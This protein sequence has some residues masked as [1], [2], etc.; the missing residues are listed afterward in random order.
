[1]SNSLF[2]EILLELK[3]KASVI[4]GKIANSLNNTSDFLKKFT[5]E[6]F[7]YVVLQSIIFITL[8]LIIIFRDPFELYAKYSLEVT[9]GMLFIFFIMF[10]TF[11]FIDH[12][13]QF[14]LSDEKGLWKNFIKKFSEWSHLPRLW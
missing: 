13:K 6:P 9:M 4:P 7:N 8:V 5:T 14:K 3:E 10:I 2:T 12:R 11:F 1:M